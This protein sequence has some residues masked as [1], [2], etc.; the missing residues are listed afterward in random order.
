MNDEQINMGS[1]N[2]HIIK[3]KKFK[4]ITVEVNFRRK[5]KK[6][7]ITIRNLLKA[8]L[9]Q[10]TKDLKTDQELIRETENLYDLKLIISNMRIGNYSNLSFKVRFLNEKYTEKSMNEYSIALLMDI[11]FNPNVLDGKFMDNDVKKCKSK[12]E[13]SIQKLTDN[14]LKYTLIKLLETTKDMPYSY[15]SFGY[16][17]DLNQITPKNLYEYYQ[18]V[19]ANDFVDVFVVGD[20]DTNEIKEIF[21]KYF[22]VNTFKKEKKDILVKELTPRNRIKKVTEQYQ[23]KQSQLTLFCTRNN[24]TEYERKYVLLVYNEMLGGS[25]NSLLF[26]TVREKNSYAYYINSN[27]KAYDNILMIYSGIEPGNSNNVL[28]L[29]KKTLQEVTKGKFL[30]ESLNNAKATIIASIKASTDS[31]TGIIN[32]Y[33]A[34]TLVNSDSFEKRIEEITKVSK[35]DIINLSKKIAMHTVYLLEGKDEEESN[36]ED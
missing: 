28:K 10:T 32:T 34:K 3:T 6:E 4:T 20:V 12:L 27:Q 24:L 19:L 9:L 23:A 22:K 26:D 33:Y 2:L 16:L 31:P 5:L 1:Y 11:L 35:E 14:K 13:K 25:S 18:S 29:I 7:E 17:E 15:N 36:G 30:D 21:K 8:V